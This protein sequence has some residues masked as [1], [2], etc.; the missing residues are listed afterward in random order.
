[1]T[2]LCVNKIGKNL[3]R[4]KNKHNYRTNNLTGNKE[5]EKNNRQQ[6]PENK[7]L[8]LEQ[9]QQEQRNTILVNSKEKSSQHQIMTKQVLEIF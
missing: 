9:E 7:I 4:K 8:R 3:K 5:A 2:V 6:Y 1:M